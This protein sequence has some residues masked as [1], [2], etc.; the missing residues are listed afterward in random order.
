[1][2]GT[3]DTYFSLGQTIN[4][5]LAMVIQCHPLNYCLKAPQVQ[6]GKQNIRKSS[7]EIRIQSYL[8]EREREKGGGGYVLTMHTYI[9][10]KPLQLKG[11]L[12]DK[13]HAERTI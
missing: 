6:A 10:L 8:R 4:S 12:L 1:M 9:I 13:N 11:A 2:Q 7:E 5:H 3:P